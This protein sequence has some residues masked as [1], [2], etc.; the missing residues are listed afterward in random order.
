MTRRKKL[1]DAIGVAVLDPELGY[2]KQR[3]VSTRDDPLWGMLSRQQIVQPQ[4]NAGRQWQEYRGNSEGIGSLRAIDTTKE[5]VDGGGS[6]PE[7]IT[8][9]QKEAV[10]AIQQARMC[11]GTFGSWLVEAVLWN[12]LSIKEFAEEIGWEKER[13]AEFLGRHFRLCLEQLARLWGL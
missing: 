6:Y 11:L 2:M 1:P 5:P 13:D 9:R 8:D 12:R 7:P 4:F 10:I 3:E